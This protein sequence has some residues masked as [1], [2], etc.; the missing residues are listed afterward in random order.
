MICRRL[1][2]KT[3]AT[4]LSLGG[5]LLAPGC[6][7]EDD[8]PARESISAPRKGGGMEDTGGEPA[9]AGAPAAPAGKAGRKLGAS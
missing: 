2:I 4:G 5:A 6:G 7:T 3:L 9:K 1:V 8:Q